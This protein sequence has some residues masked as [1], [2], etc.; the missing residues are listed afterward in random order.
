MSSGIDSACSSTCSGGGGGGSNASKLTGKLNLQPM[1][2]I[3]S[4]AWAALSDPV[5]TPT[6]PYGCTDS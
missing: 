2:M 6:D 1:S 3:M 5:R 4:P